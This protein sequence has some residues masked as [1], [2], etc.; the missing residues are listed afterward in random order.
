M[1]A[2]VVVVFVAQW[3]LVT[4][5]INSV[6]ERYVQSRLAHDADSVIAAVDVQAGGAQLRMTAL[7]SAIYQ[8]PFSGH[9]FRV[10]T[11]RAVQRSRS[12]WDQDLDVPLLAPGESRTLHLAGPQQQPLLVVLRGVSKQTV[13]LTVV[14]AE[15]IGPLQADLRRFKQYYLVVSLAALLLLL[16]L[17][18]IGLRWGLAPLQ[19]VERSLQDLRH[20]RV[21]RLN[22][23]VPQEIRPLQAE[24]NRLL[25]SLS[26]RL[27]LSRNAVSNLAHGLKT[28]LS[29][30]VRLG[31][32]NRSAA[33]A[34]LQPQIARHTGAIQQ[35]I[36][37]ELRRA[38]L[39][40]GTSVG[41]QFH[42]DADLRELAD[43]MRR[44]HR[45]PLD[46]TLDLRAGDSA[47]FDRQDMLE[48]M[49]NVIDNA[50]KWARRQVHVVARVDT[51]LRVTIDDDG[52][53]CSPEDLQRLGQRGV[54][55]DES[56][57]GHG[58]GLA[59]AGDIVD[60]YGGRLLF[61]ASESLGGLRVAIE[62]PLH[63]EPDGG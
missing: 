60:L 28:P 4:T 22:A 13:P 6:I 16:L 62:L 17:Q 56:T 31:E 27:S 2:T 61:G 12:L 45:K 9:Y 58:M 43:V 1:I 8:Q 55:L 38:Q 26:R 18:R 42:P 25:E 39:A 41:D 59:I 47:P 33:P 51:A 29:L 52:P 63:D 19:A 40:G 14:V 46:I 54:R 35:L 20:G 23:D 11:D 57:A 48:L 10:A 44:V 36:E 5:A 53:G 3:L 7:L 30:L 32:E 21:R 15:D 50:S 24:I 37:R 49:G 34:N